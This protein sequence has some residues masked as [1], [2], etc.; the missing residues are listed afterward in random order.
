MHFFLKKDYNEAITL[1]EELKTIP[2]SASLTNDFFCGQIMKSSN[3]YAAIDYLIGSCYSSLGEF[4]KALN[5]LN[6]SINLDANNQILYFER[7]KINENLENWE[8]VCKDVN[9]VAQLMQNLPTVDTS[10]WRATY[11]SKCD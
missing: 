1:L 10:V 4:D 3:S 11:A 7:I 8:N 6:N 9:K 5:A 2:S